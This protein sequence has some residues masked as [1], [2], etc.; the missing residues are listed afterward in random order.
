MWVTNSKKEISFYSAETVNSAPTSFKTLKTV[1]GVVPP[2][3]QAA[4]RALELFKDDTHWDRTLEEA[5]ISDSPYKI[6]VSVAKD[7]VTAISGKSLLHC[8]LPEL[9][10]EQSIDINNR[11]YMSEMAY[12][13]SQLIHVVFVSVPKFNHDQKKVYDDVLNS[14]DSNSGQLFFLDTPGGTGKS[15]LI[16]LLLAKVRTGKMSQH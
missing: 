8:G 11:Q 2:T 14:V 15:I 5:F 13:V 10:R 1:E 9:I 7:I 16:N 3:F 4:C 12:N 6:R